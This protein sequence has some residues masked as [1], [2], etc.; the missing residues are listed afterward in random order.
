MSTYMVNLEKYIKMKDGRVILAVKTPEQLKKK[1]Q[2]EVRDMF[3]GKEVIVTNEEGDHQGD[4]FLVR[5][6]EMMGTD[7][8]EVGDS[9]GLLVTHK[10]K[11]L[12]ADSW[13]PYQE[14]IAQKEM[15]ENM[16]DEQRQRMAYFF[17]NNFS[18]KGYEEFKS[19]N[20]EYVETK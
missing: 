16:T 2:L 13:M 11:S 12:T 14:Y 19:K 4:C 17:W 8:R 15:M 5:G 3:M 7:D 9:M 1:T 10:P 20:Q 18:H 6:F